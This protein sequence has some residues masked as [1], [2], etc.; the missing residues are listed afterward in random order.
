MK[1]ATKAEYGQRHDAN[2]HIPVTK[3][4]SQ[5]TRGLDVVRPMG[6]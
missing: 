1:Y 6:R 4:W 3:P 2:T 5:A